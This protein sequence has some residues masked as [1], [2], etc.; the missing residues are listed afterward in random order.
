MV[1]K[2]V[3]EDVFRF[4]DTKDNDPEQCWPWIGYIHPQ[5][6]RGYFSLEGKRVLA[7]R[8][9]YE[10]INGEIGSQLI[11]HKCDNPVCC[12]PTHLELGSQGDNED[13]KYTRDRWGY[14]N[15]MILEMR[16]LRKF[17]MSYRKIAEMV[18]KKFD[19]EISHTGVAKILNEETHSSKR[20]DEQL[21][22]ETED[23]DARRASR[24]QAGSS[25]SSEDEAGSSR[26]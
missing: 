23:A 20:T 17:N 3:P 11:R 9:V 15:D 1:R 8:V 18:G 10:L 12:N 6:G 13:D 2:N 14:T 4:I 7:Y 16:R 5:N 25:G 21:R 19:C 24:D 26:E 22:K